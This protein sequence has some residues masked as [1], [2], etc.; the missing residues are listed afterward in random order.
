MKLF[1]KKLSGKHVEILLM[2]L[3]LALAIYV[4]YNRNEKFT[5]HVTDKP[6]LHMFMAPWCGHSQNL[7]PIWE[8]VKKSEDFKD[9]LFNK[10]NC[11][12]QIEMCNKYKIKGL[13]TLIFEKMDGTQ[14]VYKNK[15]TEELITEF[16]ESNL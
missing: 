11:D 9:I 3:V 15:N 6:T 14:I 10:V 8:N 2:L 7:L 1:F 4:V 5:N 12:D 16:L 13:P